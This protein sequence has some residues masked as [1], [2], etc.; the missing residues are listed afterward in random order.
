M[1]KISIVIPCYNEEEAIP[2]YYEEM[3]KIMF[4]MKQ[5]KFEL[6]FVDDG[7]RD[8]T[9]EE[10]RNL[11]NKDKRCCYLSF[12]RNFG[13]EAA[14]Y[15]GLSY[16]TGDY[17]TVMDVDLQDPPALIPKMYGLLSKKDC[18]CVATR[19][20]DREGEPRFRSFL[21]SNFYKIINKI[22][23]TE[24]VEGARDYRMMKRKMVDAVLYMNEYNR[25]SKGIFQWVGFSTVWLEFKNTQRCAGETKWSLRKLFTYSLEGIMGFS[26]APLSLASIAGIVFCFIS[27][28]MV[29]VI[30]A[31]TL[32]FGDP[33]A[34]WTSLVCIVFLVSGVQLFC[35][36]ILGQYLSK[37]YLETKRRPIYI[38]KESSGEKEKAEK[39]LCGET[40]YEKV[41]ER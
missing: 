37:T 34:G 27:F 12:S 32:I 29:V 38:V 19:R 35:M 24:I 2:V 20:A 30:A 33:V 4:F 10:L 5:V 14:I 6:I 1:E 16:A 21:S 13:K 36:G 25:F 31:R 11:A 18:D 41:V 28:L 3:K 39:K 9:L 17:V 8:K 22:S 26:V 40:R 15:A 23:D 7:S